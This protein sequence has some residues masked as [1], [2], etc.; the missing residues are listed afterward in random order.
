MACTWFGESCSCCC[1]IVLLGPAWVLLSKI[2]KP[3][4]GSLYSKIQTIYMMFTHSTQERH[5]CGRDCPEVQERGSR[6]LL[7]IGRK[8]GAD[9]LLS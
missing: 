8:G 3:F 9:V 4:A 6:V 2:Y 5:G 1:L 7:D